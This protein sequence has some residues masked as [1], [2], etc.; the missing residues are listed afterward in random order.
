MVRVQNCVVR[1]VAW[2]VL[3]WSADGCAAGRHGLVMAHF[4]GRISD[5]LPP[6]LQPP[7]RCWKGVNRSHVCKGSHL[8]ARSEMTSANRRS[9]LHCE[10]FE[11]ILL[12]LCACVTGSP[13]SPDEPMIHPAPPYRTA[14]ID[15]LH[16]RWPCSSWIVRKVYGVRRRWPT[17]A[18]S[19][20]MASAMHASSDCPPC[21]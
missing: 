10:L 18:G 3:S 16:T 9:K 5:R 12:S 20:R 2:L 8:S 21:S 1:P 6:V 19:H 7:S 15:M 13:C 11:H 17:N 4:C 14:V